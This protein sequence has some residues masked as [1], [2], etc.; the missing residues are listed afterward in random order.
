MSEDG[1]NGS[2]Y[3]TLAKHDQSETK[4]DSVCIDVHII[5]ALCTAV[6]RFLPLA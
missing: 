2:L 6:T 3:E 5:F 4:C 1:P